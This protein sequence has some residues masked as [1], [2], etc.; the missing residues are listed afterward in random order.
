M[1]GLKR[2]ELVALVDDAIAKAASETGQSPGYALLSMSPE[3]RS[4]VA[5]ELEPKLKQE[6]EQ[7]A[8]RLPKDRDRFTT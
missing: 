5:R 4:V 2:Q 6:C 1:D 7:L 8:A 3:F